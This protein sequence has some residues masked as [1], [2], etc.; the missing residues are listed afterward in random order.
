MYLHTI[1]I[2]AIRRR[3]EDRKWGGLPYRCRGCEIL[4]ICRRPQ[5]EGWKCYHGCIL[6]NQQRERE[7]RKNKN[8]G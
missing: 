1:I 2:N 8:N 3:I 7:K 6:L 5:S 4:G